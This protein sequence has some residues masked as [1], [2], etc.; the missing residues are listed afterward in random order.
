MREHGV[1]FISADPFAAP[2][3]L[4]T[5]SFYSLMKYDT[6]SI[7]TIPNINLQSLIIVLPLGYIWGVKNQ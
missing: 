5:V 7:N 6:W 1:C 4:A 3:F 2:G